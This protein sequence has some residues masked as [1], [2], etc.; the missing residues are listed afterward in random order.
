MVTKSDLGVTV[1]GCMI[2]EDPTPQS[3]AEPAEGLSGLRLGLDRAVGITL[4]YDQLKSM[5][6]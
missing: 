2:I 6:L 5:A 1:L 4:E 3:R